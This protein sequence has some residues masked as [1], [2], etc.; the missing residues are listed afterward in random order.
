MPNGSTCYSG[1]AAAEPTHAELQPMPLHRRALAAP[2]ARASSQRGMQARSAALG[3]GCGTWPTTWVRSSTN[4]PVA[5]A[6]IRYL[7]V[8]ALAAVWQH[9]LLYC[10]PFFHT[11]Q[12]ADWLLTGLAGLQTAGGFIAPI[13]A[14]VC[15]ECQQ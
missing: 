12:C 4:M 8:P 5:R 11:I 15:P 10:S 1:D 13:I 2:A 7:T 6:C 3:G 9:E 14:G